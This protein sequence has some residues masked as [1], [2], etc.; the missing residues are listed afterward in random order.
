MG[1][2][3]IM[4][5][6]LSFVFALCVVASSGQSSYI[7][8]S[9]TVNDYTGDLN[10][11]HF[12]LFRYKSYKPGI[13]I[14]LQQ[15]G[16]PFFNFMETLSYDWVQYQNDAKTAGVD[17]Q[18]L[19]LDF[20]LKYKF[21]NGYQLREDAGVAPFLLLGAGGT[22]LK[23]HQF[24]NGTSVAGI[25]EGVKANLLAGLGLTFRINETVSFEIASKVY[26]PLYD[27]WDGITKG[28]NDI[29]AN[30]IYVQH[31]AGLVFGIN[32]S[33]DSDGDGVRDRKDQCPGTPRGVA[34]DS[35][36]CPQDWDNDGV[37]DYLDRCPRVAGSKILD[38]CPDR[39]H[40]FVAD[41]D[42]AC[43][44]VPGL[45]SN[46]GCPDNN[47]NRNNNYDPDSDGDGVPDSRDKCPNS[48]RGS[49]VDATGC[50]PA[51]TED[52]TDTDGDGVPDR[53]DRCPNTPGPKSNRGCPEISAEVK[54]R[55]KFATRGIYF[56]TAKA[57]IKP[58][59]YPMLNEV[60]DII[61]Q[62][63]DYDLRVS[64]HTDNVG[65]DSYNME[66]SQARV[67]AVKRYLSEKGISA[68][69]LDAIGYGKTRPVATNS[70]A[71]GRAL[72]RRVELEL[73]LK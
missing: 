1:Y 50:P 67:D 42:D 39:D 40:D 23:S 47:S 15:Y 72:N 44:D 60:V 33:P 62:Y 24:I 64:G 21:D 29:W 11:N 53:I 4:K 14:S 28:G 9:G 54:K 16:S 59:S 70:T 26:M 36:G 68:S 66:L 18:F 69:R 58:E 10:G 12:G 3:N 35:R 48:P 49:V 2:T 52:N 56:E 13:A 25:A 5:Y 7:G 19:S 46:H 37:P 27:G 34:V 20:Q 30:D 43:P 55:L 45:V 17:A 31:S 6:V 71:V 65:G 63:P 8:F 51:S 22:Y 73:F 57:I 41:I 38:G 61:N 32:K